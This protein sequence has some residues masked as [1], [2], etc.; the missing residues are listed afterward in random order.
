MMVI[1]CWL[2]PVLA[3]H[4]CSCRKGIAGAGAG[5]GAGDGT[6]LDDGADDLL[7]YLMFGAASS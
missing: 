7:V 2:L 3:Y 1:P 6:D 4:A 5:A